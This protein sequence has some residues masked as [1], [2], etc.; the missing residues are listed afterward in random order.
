MIAELRLGN[1]PQIGILLQDRR[2]DLGNAPQLGPWFTIAQLS[3]GNVF[4][5]CYIAP[6]AAS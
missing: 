2:V 3:L 6:R 4:T 5:A 1:A